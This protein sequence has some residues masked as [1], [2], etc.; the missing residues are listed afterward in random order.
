MS[1]VRGQ[2]IHDRAGQ[3]VRAQFGA[4]LQDADAD[5]LAFVGGQL[6][7]ADGGGQAGRS[8][9]DHDHVIFHR[10]AFRH[11]QSSPYVSHVWLE[12]L[13]TIVL[14]P[15]AVPPSHFL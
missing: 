2:R 9:A 8:A 7:Q 6:L 3:R 4:F 10:L 1:S 15:E 13:S 12:V 14:Q 5:F 11:L